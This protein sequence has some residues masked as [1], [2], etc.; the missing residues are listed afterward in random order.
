MQVSR[1]GWRQ[2]EERTAVPAVFPFALTS[3]SR[4]LSF[5]HEAATA[6]DQAVGTLENLSPEWVTSCKLDRD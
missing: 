4:R 6:R 5:L 3:R 1:P 2:E